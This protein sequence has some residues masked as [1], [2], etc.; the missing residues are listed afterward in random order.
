[1]IDVEVK[2]SAIEIGEFRMGIH[3]T[4]LQFALLSTPYIQTKRLG[5]LTNAEPND[6][7]RQKEI[8]IACNMHLRVLRS[9][10]NRSLLPPNSMIRGPNPLQS[11]PEYTHTKRRITL[12]NS[13]DW[14]LYPC[15]QFNTKSDSL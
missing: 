4:A 13:F 9:V 1:M 10:S 15:S 11:D 6:R 5:Y 3:L 14:G 12:R 2:L 7:K 8:I